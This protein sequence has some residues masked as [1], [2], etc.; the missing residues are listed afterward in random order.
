MKPLAV[1]HLAPSCER[2]RM[3]WSEEDEAL[4]QQTENVS[5]TSAEEL[6][7]PDVA[8][9]GGDN[10]IVGHG[11]LKALRLSM[12]SPGSADAGAE[13]VKKQVGRRSPELSRALEIVRRLTKADQQALVET[14]QSDIVLT[15]ATQPESPSTVPAWAQSDAETTVASTCDLSAW[16]PPDDDI[17][18]VYEGFDWLL[19]DLEGPAK[20]W[21]KAA[22]PW[23]R[24]KL[25]TSLRTLE[26][27]AQAE[28]VLEPQVRNQC[29][30][31]DPQQVASPPLD[32][33]TI[34]EL[35]SEGQYDDE[36][37]LVDLDLF[38]GD[39]TFCCD[40]FRTHHPGDKGD[41]SYRKAEDMRR[42]SETLKDEF[43]SELLNFRSHVGEGSGHVFVAREPKRTLSDAVWATAGAPH[44]SRAS[45]STAL[46]DACANISGGAVVSEARRRQS[47]PQPLGLLG[48]ALK[49]ASATKTATCTPKRPRRRRGRSASL[50]SSTSPRPNS[51][52]PPRRRA[53]AHDD[54]GCKVG[55]RPEAMATPLVEIDTAIHKWCCVKLRRVL[56][57]LG[58]RPEAELLF[59]PPV[60]GRFAFKGGLEALEDFVDF[61]VI[62]DRLAGEQYLAP[63]GYI[64]PS[65]FWDDLDRCWD[66]CRCFFGD[67]ARSEHFLATEAMRATAEKAKA[68][69]WADLERLEASMVEVHSLDDATATEEDGNTEGGQFGFHFSR[70][71]GASSDATPFNKLLPTI[72]AVTLACSAAMR[73]RSARRPSVF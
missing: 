25:Q 58:G 2:R 59:K 67:D 26:M 32:L 21:R 10:A 38:W 23:C 4:G 20:A 47:A 70:H 63:D 9:G 55:P 30:A 37:G 41:A 18:R 15:R 61:S 46:A 1:G 69:F 49:V 36:D 62:R 66:C 51:C 57:V 16:D 64:D 28:P 40:C 45:S 31:N 53:W 54:C 42:A 3:E 73:Q 44:D 14:L 68:T 43:F 35:L 6:S 72:S 12:N 17:S 7:G 65:F 29:G 13:P 33:R 56:R 34:T 39:V 24:K 71:L 60:S 48:N 19:K 11:G 50:S 52:D 5:L 8:A 27:R 22:E